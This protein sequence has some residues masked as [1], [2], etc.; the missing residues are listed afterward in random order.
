MSC[1]L[2]SIVVMLML[3]A[4]SSGCSR[5]WEKTEDIGV[6]SII[7]HWREDLWAWE[8]GSR[9]GVEYTEICNKSSGEC[10]YKGSLGLLA[11]K[12]NAEIVFSGRGDYALAF[13]DN[14]DGRKISPS[15]LDVYDVSSGE[16]LNCQLDFIVDRIGVA[17]FKGFSWEGKRG[18][19][20]IGSDEPSLGRFLFFLSLEGGGCETRLLR[21]YPDDENEGRIGWWSFN[22]ELMEVAWSFCDESCRVMAINLLTGSEDSFSFERCATA[23]STGFLEW[24]DGKLTHY[25]NESN[26]PPPVQ[27]PKS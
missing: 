13:S 21:N 15:M 2:A 18:V 20:L 6:F 4:C 19:G 25:C 22:E 27:K 1:R 11:R 12:V 3:L 24:R 26:F 9:T 23:P 10:Y 17:D 14:I 8:L 7:Q 16:R 5:K